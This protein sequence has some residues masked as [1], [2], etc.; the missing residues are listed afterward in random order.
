M[1]VIW[2]IDCISQSSPETQIQQ[3]LLHLSIYIYIKYKIIHIDIYSITHTHTHRCNLR[4]WCIWLW[5]L[6]SQASRLKT[7]AKFLCY[8]LKAEFFLSRKLQVLFLKPSVNWMMPNHITESN[9]LYLKWTDWKQYSHLQSMFT[10]TS[11]FVFDQTTK[12]HSLAK[13]TCKLIITEI[14]M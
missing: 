9:L 7:K 6:A 12:H 11:R 3:N 2:K 1:K 13:L 10:A 8:N 14:F 5:R 4:N